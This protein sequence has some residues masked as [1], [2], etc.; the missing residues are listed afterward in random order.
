MSRIPISKSALQWLEDPVTA[1]N[2]A[3]LFLLAAVFCFAP[4][5]RNY[6]ALAVLLTLWTGHKI[7][8]FV[9]AQRRGASND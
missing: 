3:A 5:P 4:S 8:R 6:A 2:F 9:T 7:L 1:H